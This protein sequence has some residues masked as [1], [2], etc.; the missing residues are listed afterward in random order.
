MKCINKFVSCVLIASLSLS[1]TACKGEQEDVT[2]Y[3]LYDTSFEYGLTQN[4]ATSDVDLF[5]KNLCIS[6][7]DDIGTSNV[8]SQ[9]A[10]GAGAFNIT[11]QSPV[12]AQ[13]VH[14]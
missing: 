6:N 13:S 4:G 12:Y 3:N 11:K 9:V 5:A 14:E 7:T 8:D 10:S 1:L 2:S